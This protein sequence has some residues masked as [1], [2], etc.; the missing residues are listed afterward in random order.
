MFNFFTIYLY[1]VASNF[2]KT[3]IPFIYFA[4]EYHYG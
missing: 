1:F 4:A 2:A 3:E